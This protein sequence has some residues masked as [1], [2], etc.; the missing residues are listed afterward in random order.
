MAQAER[1]RLFLNGKF[2][3]GAT[4]GVSRGADR[5]IRELDRLAVAGE[6]PAAWDM[7]LLLPLKANWAPTFD[8]IV[9]VPQ[10]RGH[11]QAWEQFG[12]PVA[13]RGGVLASFANLALALARADIGPAVRAFASD[14]IGTIDVQIARA[15]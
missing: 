6:A 13:A 8:A 11:S 7:R 12:L 2:Y 15:A 5:L 10:W 14:L 9:P 4:N 3:A 1:P